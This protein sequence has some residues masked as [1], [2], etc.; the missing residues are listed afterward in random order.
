MISYETEVIVDRSV[1][2]VYKFVTDVALFDDWTEMS[3]TRL[4]SGKDLRV[5]SQI[6]T[7]L[8]MGPLKQAMVFE[9]EALEPNRRLGFKTVSKGALDWD[10]DFTFEARGPSSTRVVSSGQLRLNGVLKLSEPLIAGEV[11][12]GEAKELMKMKELVEAQS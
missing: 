11:K 10:A 5:G 1:E 8:N 6:E 2:Q 7:T 4:V 12:S 3:G 9:V